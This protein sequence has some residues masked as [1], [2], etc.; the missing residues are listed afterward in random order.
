[1]YA[2]FGH[3][4]NS[5]KYSCQLVNATFEKPSSLYSAFF[6]AYQYIRWSHVSLGSV[7]L[8]GDSMLQAKQLDKALV[9][10]VGDL[11]A[12]P[13]S[14]AF[15]QMAAVLPWENMSL[16]LSASVFLISFHL[17]QIGTGFK[18]ED[19]EHH[20]KFLKVKWHNMTE[21]NSL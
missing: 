11:L 10:Q 6:F 19:L 2:A 5:L 3:E 14:A 15:C 8:R 9:G 1:M 16:Y 18:D 20:Y 12:V 4:Q 17:F 13:Y 21:L 7:L